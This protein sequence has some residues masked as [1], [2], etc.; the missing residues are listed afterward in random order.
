MMTTATKTL[1]SGKTY[2]T[3]FRNG[4]SGA[5]TQDYEWTGSQWE[6]RWIA[7]TWKCKHGGVKTS[8]YVGD[9]EANIDHGT[10]AVTLPDGTQF[11]GTYQAGDRWMAITID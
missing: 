5:E 10:V 9:G 3:E 6:R 1:E 8:Q 4:V 7:C 2:T 11:S